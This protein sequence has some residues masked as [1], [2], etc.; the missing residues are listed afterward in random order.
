MITSDNTDFTAG[1]V[2][3][4]QMPLLFLR[5][6]FPKNKKKQ[7]EPVSLKNGHQSPIKRSKVT[8]LPSATWTLQMTASMDFACIVSSEL[9]RF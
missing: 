7:G 8:G 1:T 4:L 3:V 5:V 6:S 9:F 2:L